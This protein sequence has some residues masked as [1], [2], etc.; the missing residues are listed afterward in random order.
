MVRVLVLNVAAEKGGALAILTAF[1]E[2]VRQSGTHAWRFVVGRSQLTESRDIRVSAFPW[3]KRSWFHRAFFDVFVAPTLV[4]RLKPDVVLSLQNVII[5]CVSVRQVVYLHQAIP[6]SA[7]RFPFWSQPKLWVYQN[8]ISLLILWSVRRADQ[9][10][11]QSEWM[12]QELVERRDV[13]GRNI[14][15]IRPDVPAVTEGGQFQNRNEN[16]HRFFYPASAEVYKRHNVILEACRLLETWGFRNFTVVL[17]VLP[18]SLLTGAAGDLPRAVDARGPMS[19]DQV[20]EEYSRSVLVFPSVVESLAL[21]LSEARSAG[22]PI[23]ASDT[24]FARE[25]LSGY[26]NSHYFCADSAGQLATLMS[27]CILNKLGYQ[28]VPFTR[29]QNWNGWNELISLVRDTGAMQ[30]GEL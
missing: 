29:R 9:V 11:V 19:P 30:S 14:H 17:T 28:D 3:V 23:L 26:V 21:P 18:K 8:V 15:V 16:F 24:P 20:W 1:F 4:R 13:P 2:S 10:V 22:C 6:F 5:P 7:I 27:N 12:K 25:A